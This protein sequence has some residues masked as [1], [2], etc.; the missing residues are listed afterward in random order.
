M[1]PDFKKKL[2]LNL[3]LMGSGPW[4]FFAKLS[5]YQHIRVQITMDKYWVIFQKSNFSL[6]TQQ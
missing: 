5:A 1:Q 6:V 2:L 3:L 4:T